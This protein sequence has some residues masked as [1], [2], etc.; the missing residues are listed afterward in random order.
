MVKGHIQPIKDTIKQLKIGIEVDDF[1]IYA[2]KEIPGRFDE[3]IN[4]DIYLKKGKIELKLLIAKIFFG[5]GYYRPWVELFAISPVLDFGKIQL[6]Y[7]DSPI[8]AKILELFSKSL[9]PGS[10]MYVEYEQDKET[11]YILQQGLAMPISRL[12]YLLYKNGFTWFKDW[13]FP[14]GYLEGGRKLEGEKPL[15]EKIKL[16]QLKRIQ[17]EV[18][19]SLLKLKDYE[20]NDYIF[21]G[22][23][24][25]KKILMK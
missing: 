7:F 20:E 17:Q 22:L 18:K 9:E 2:N 6:R 19:E 24:R 16:A 25:A 15:N 21:R 3:E 8:E 1:L 12:G 10:Y 4:L 13:Y 23:E 5:R 14:E 11:L